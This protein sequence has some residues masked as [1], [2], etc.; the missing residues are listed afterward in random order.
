MVNF[1]PDGWLLPDELNLI[2]NI[3][4]L[5]KKSIAFCEEERG[6]LKESY[7][8][9]YIIPVVEH[10]PWQK[11][12]IPIPAAKVKKFIKLVGKRVCTSLY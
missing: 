2:K 4:S 10:D 12:N 1:G 3:L 7:G 8:L 5:R 6:L 9:P 11:K